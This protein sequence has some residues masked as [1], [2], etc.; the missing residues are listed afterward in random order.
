MFGFK[1]K[2]GRGAGQAKPHEDRQPVPMSRMLKN[3][4]KQLEEIFCGDNDFV[5]RCFELQA[6]KKTAASIFYIDGL[7][8]AETINSSILNPLMIESRKLPDLE[9]RRFY[10]MEEVCDLFLLSG[11]I[12]IGNDILKACHAI[13]TG[14]TVLMIDGIDKFTVVS[15]KGF[16]KRSVIEPETETV[17]RGPREGFTELIRTNTSLLRRKI[18]SPNLRMESMQI[19][20]RSNTQVCLAYIDNLANPEL[21]KEVKKRLSTIDTDAILSDGAIED[22]IEDAPSSV[23]KTINSTEKPDIVAARLLEGRCALLVDGSPFALT[24]PMFFIESLQSPEDYAN[25]TF[26]ATFSRLLRILAFVLA[27]IAPA[28]Y[29]ALTSFHQELI[30]TALLFTISAATE[31]IPFS[32]ITE[33]AIM[34]ISFEVLKEAGI[35]LPQPIGQAVSIVGALVVGQAAIDAGIVGAPVVIVTAFTAVCTFVVPTLSDSISILRWIFLVAAGLMGGLG[36]AMASI[37][38][39]THLASLESFGSYYLYPGSPFDITDLQDTLIRKPLWK[40]KTRPA[41]LKPQDIVRQSTPKTE[42][43]EDGDEL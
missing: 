19:G 2:P 13:L 1:Q 28:V 5:C 32:T 27:I 26:Y 30:P 40:L 6:F 31:K 12:E 33:T 10:K 24:M 39:M 7:A 25:R 8:S 22:Y 29:V 18:T 43:G 16:D 17:V 21:V 42:F 15:T 23:F 20:R 36:I 3:N 4:I 41:D 34:L 11:S 14:D 9:D 37:A 38:I 35:R